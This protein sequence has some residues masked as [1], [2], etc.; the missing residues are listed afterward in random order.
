MVK[1]ELE[2]R[3]KDINDET[4]IACGL[5]PPRDVTLWNTTQHFLTMEIDFFIF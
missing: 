3:I 4:Y 2:G 1:S 5:L